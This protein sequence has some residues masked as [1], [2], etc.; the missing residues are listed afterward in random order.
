MV[1]RKYK[2][3]F[4]S[5]TGNIQFQHTKTLKFDSKQE[6][7]DWLQKTLSEDKYVEVDS[8]HD[9]MVFIPVR[10]ITQIKV[11]EIEINTEENNNG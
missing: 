5:F 2:F 11:K 8:E 4:W 7:R 1:Y 9:E 10:C 3:Q 6:A